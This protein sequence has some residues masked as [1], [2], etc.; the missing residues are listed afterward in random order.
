MNYETVPRD[1]KETAQIRQEKIVNKL[2]KHPSVTGP[3]KPCQSIFSSPQEI[4]HAPSHLN[5]SQYYS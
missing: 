4:L 2:A 3:R 5:F 1:L